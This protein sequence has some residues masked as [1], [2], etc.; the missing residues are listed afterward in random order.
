MIIRKL[1][2]ADMLT[3]GAALREEVEAGYSET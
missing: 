2:E 1:A 3:V